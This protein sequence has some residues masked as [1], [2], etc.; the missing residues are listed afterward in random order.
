MFDEKSKVLK[1]KI[2]WNLMIKMNYLF[3]YSLCVGEEMF[4]MNDKRSKKEILMSN[5]QI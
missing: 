5:E 3:D 2:K 1:L 4:S